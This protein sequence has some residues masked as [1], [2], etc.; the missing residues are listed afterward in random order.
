LALARVAPILGSAS[1]AFGAWYV[2]GAAG[3]IAFPF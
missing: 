1:L 3:A 2:L